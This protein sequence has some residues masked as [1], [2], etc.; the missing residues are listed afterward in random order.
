M[1]GPRS[2]STLRIKGEQVNIL[3]RQEKYEQAE[4]VAREV[5][6]LRR[7]ALGAQHVEIVTAMHSLGTVLEKVGKADEA[8]ALRREERA[9]RETG[10]E[11]MAGGERLAGLRDGDGMLAMKEGRYVEAERIFREKLVTGM[12]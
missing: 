8:E 12:A 4:R 7:E 6:A 10:R 1:N 5:L 11:E 2:P 9:L 3:L